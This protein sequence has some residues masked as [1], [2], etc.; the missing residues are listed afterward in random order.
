MHGAAGLVV[1]GVVLGGLRAL[2]G[3]GQSYSFGLLDY[4]RVEG[5]FLAC[6]A[7]F[8]VGGSTSVLGVER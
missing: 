1:I 4:F 3:C 6:G 7:S 2:S 8:S 5:S